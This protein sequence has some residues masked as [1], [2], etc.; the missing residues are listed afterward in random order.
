LEYEKKSA[1]QHQ[2][3]NPAKEQKRPE[4]GWTIFL[5]VKVLIDGKSEQFE[6]STRKYLAD[7]KEWN[8]KTK[9]VKVTQMQCAE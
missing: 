6:I 5:R 9:S 4:G 1:W 8:N 7:K 3:T 2:S